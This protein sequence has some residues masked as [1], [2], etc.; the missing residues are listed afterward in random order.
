MKVIKQLLEVDVAFVHEIIASRLYRNQTH[1]LR[2]MNC[3]FCKIDECRYG[4][5]QIQQR[6]HLHTTFVMMQ[7]SP[8]TKLKA[9][10][11]S[12]AIKGVHDTIHVKTGRFILVQLSCPSNQYLTEIMVYT[13]ILGLIDMSQSGT[14]D[15]LYSARIEFGREC[16]QRCIN[17]AETNLV[18]ELRKAHHH[19]L[20]SAFELDGMS[21]AIVS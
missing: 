20:V 10:L 3:S 5:T 7:T 9:Q 19:K 18:S 15:I 4:T 12:A 11:D 6:M 14:L 13:P 16:N 17:A 1:C 2:V 21:I 8:W